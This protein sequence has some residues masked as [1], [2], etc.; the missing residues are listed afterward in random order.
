MIEKLSH[1]TQVQIFKSETLETQLSSLQL[2]L[3]DREGELHMK[4]L[5]ISSLT[6]QLSTFKDLQHEEKKKQDFYEENL[7]YLK[8]TIEQQRTDLNSMKDR[9]TSTDA[10]IREAQYARDLT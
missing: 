6:H 9:L 4:K 7:S 3:Q 2:L 8:A 1:D 10:A 5:E